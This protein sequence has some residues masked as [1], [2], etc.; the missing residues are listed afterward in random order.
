MSAEALLAKDFRALPELIRAHAAERPNHPALIEGYETLTYGGLA[1]LMGRIAFAF[2]R[3][4]VRSGD[5]VAICA[6]TSINYA[7]AFCGVLAAGAAVAPLAPSSTPAS[8][9]MML[10]DCGAG[11]FLLDRETAEALKETGYEVLVRRVALDDSEAGEP[12]PEWIVPDGAKSAD[13]SI[14]PEQ[15]FNIIYSSGTTGAPKPGFPTRTP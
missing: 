10:G 4:G 9:M 12:F 15:P 7:A 3:D 8:L 13:L 2:E 1:A 6:R 11:V 5:A 14:A